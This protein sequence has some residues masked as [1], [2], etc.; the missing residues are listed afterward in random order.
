MISKFDQAGFVIFCLVFMSCD[1][2]IHWYATLWY[3]YGGVD[4]NE[5]EW[6][7]GR[8]GCNLP[9]CV[10]AY[11]A[12]AWT[13]WTCVGELVS[14][15]TSMFRFSSRHCHLDAERS[16][17]MIADASEVH[18]CYYFTVFYLKSAAIVKGRASAIPV[19]ELRECTLHC[20]MNSKC[21]TSLLHVAANSGIIT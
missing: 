10:L 8:F 16:F 18:V 5:T 17:W 20:W 12:R 4:C 15:Q 13:C 19:H 21:E 9:V 3:R 2:E 14:I 7:D 6:T 11:T 1:F